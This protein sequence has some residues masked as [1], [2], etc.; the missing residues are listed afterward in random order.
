MGV[1]ELA[2]WVEFEI[3]TCTMYIIILLI[4]HFGQEVTNDLLFCRRVSQS[5]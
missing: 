4:L 1:Y 3:I 2:N 5:E